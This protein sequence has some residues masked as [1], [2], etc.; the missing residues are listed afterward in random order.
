MGFLAALVPLLTGLA[1]P[2][3]DY[4]NYKI[5]KAKDT[6]ELELARISA[7]KEAIISGNAA[8][9][10]QRSNYLNS[11]TQN[12]RQW[13]IIFFFIPF[14]ISMVMPGYAKEMWANF[15]AIP[16][17]F[18][19]Y[20]FI[21]YGVILGLPIAK[22]YFGAFLSS[23]SSGLASRREFKLALNEAKIA[24]SL[25]QSIFKAGMTQTQWDAIKAALESGKSD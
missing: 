18:K 8:D 11:V 13:A 25:R 16:K 1:Q 6:Q 22:E 14:L 7:E 10:A 5:Q 4:F 23:V 20:F 24:A 2:F 15:D 19:Q 9:T 12:F 21:I 17:D 3:K